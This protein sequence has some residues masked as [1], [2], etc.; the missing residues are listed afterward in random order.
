MKTIQNSL[1]MYISQV[2]EVNEQIDSRSVANNIP[3]ALWCPSCGVTWKCVSRLLS[4]V[5]YILAILGILKFGTSDIFPMHRW[6]VFEKRQAG[7][8]SLLCSCKEPWIVW[9]RHTAFSWCYVVYVHVV[10]KI[11][12]LIFLHSFT[13][14]FHRDCSSLSEYVHFMCTSHCAKKPPS[15]R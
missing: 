5:R 10:Y 12:K 9:L 1:F 3:P 2:L 6:Y 8:F 11:L 14:L 13:E 7:L 15:T 4:Y